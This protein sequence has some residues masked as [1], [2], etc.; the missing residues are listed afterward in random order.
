MRF[1]FA[2]AGRIV[3]GPGAP[4]EAGAV[5]ADLG[6]RALVVVGTSSPRA[7]ALFDALG[8]R[9]IDCVTLRV[10]SEPTV[11]L[12][13]SGAAQIRQAGCDLVIAIGGGSAL[14]TGKAVAALATNPGD[15]LD[16]LEVIGKGRPIVNPPLPVIAIP[17]TAGTGAEVTR[18][19]VLASPEQRVK[20]SLRS[21][22]MLPRVAL[23]DPELTHSVPPNVTASTGM[24]A[25]TQLIEPF[26]SVRANPLTD[27]L[28]QEG[29]GRA[30]RALR[31]VYADG[32]DAEA[33][34][35]MALAS[36]FGGLALANAG[37]GAV[38]GF[39]GPLGGMFHA[40]HGA[41]CAALLPHVVA[42]NIAA[43][44]QRQPHSPALQRYDQIARILTGSPN[45][46]ADD[47]ASWLRA[48]LTDLNIPPLGH[49]GITHDHFDTI[50][51]AS[52]RAS[53]MKANPIVLTD[54]E[55][56]SILESA[57]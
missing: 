49:Y 31:R 21:P 39:A 29:M 55:L 9:G 27:A 22:L 11:D 25:L 36:L 51:E 33:R 12:A 26:V 3:F 6:K 46:R 30:A 5:A 53:S 23:V 15:P 47:A 4:A 16:Y 13:A 20:V 24:D 17:T 38:H 32:S 10:S 35:D 54:D 40:P 14:D 19:A 1:E 7:Q 34:A 8:E 52:A 57:L 44:R 42:A 45:A 28:C 43:L 50:V 37:L 48:L 56:A 2:S 41:L 18:N